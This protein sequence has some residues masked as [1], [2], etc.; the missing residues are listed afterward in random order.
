[1]KLRIG[2]ALA[3]LILGAAALL[4]PSTALADGGLG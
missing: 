1:M 2:I 4:A 3:F